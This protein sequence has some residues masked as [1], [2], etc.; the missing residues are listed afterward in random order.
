MIRPLL[1]RP[2]R[3]FLLWTAST[4]WDIL[5]IVRFIGTTRILRAF[6]LGNNYRWL[7]R[8][9][10]ISVTLFDFLAIIRLHLVHFLSLSDFFNL[11]SLLPFKHFKDLFF[12]ASTIT[13]IFF[14]NHLLIRGIS[15]S[16]WSLASFMNILSVKFTWFSVPCLYFISSALS[17]S[18]ISFLLIVV[19]I[20][21]LR[22]IPLVLRYSLP[23]LVFR[24]FQVGFCCNVGRCLWGF[25]FLLFFSL[26]FIELWR[27]FWAFH[28]IQI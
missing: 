15:R 12:L 3:K 26:V 8:W 19:N 11:L 4:C 27:R 17:E 2:V 28:F 18:D 13:K 7:D 21:I 20:W 1:R 14:C 24:G 22:W 23:T 16:W 5:K 6:P 9:T 25:L 10:W